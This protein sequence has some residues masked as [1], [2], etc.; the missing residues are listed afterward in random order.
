MKWLLV[1]RRS[2]LMELGVDRLVNN[3]SGLAAMAAE[4]CQLTESFPLR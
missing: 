4:I 3:S 1:P 2:I